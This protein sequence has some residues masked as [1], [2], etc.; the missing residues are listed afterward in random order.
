MNFWHQAPFGRLLLP[1]IGGILCS[2]F[3]AFPAQAVFAVTFALLFVYLMLH[4]YLQKEVSKKLELLTGVLIMLLFFGIGFL[5][6]NRYHELNN[7]AH[8]SY[9]LSDYKTLQ[10]V[11]AP[12][13]KARSVKIT[14]RVT[15]IHT[16][17][18]WEN[19]AGKMLVYLQRDSLSE[20]L[21]Y[22]DVLLCNV[23]EQ[24]V[25]PPRNPGEFNYKRYLLFNNIFHQCYIPSGGFEILQRNQ[26][27]TIFAFAYRIRASL[28]QLFKT[29]VKE[30]KEAAVS[31]ALV[32][33]YV[34]ELDPDLIQ[35]Y[36]NT[37]TLHVLAVSGMHVGIIFVVL[38]MM[39]GFMD[40][41]RKTA[42]LKAILI[43]AFLWGYS[44]VAGLSPSILRAATMFSFITIGQLLKRSSSIYNT[45]AASAFIM[46]LIK[47]TI[48]ASVGFQL[49]YAA[50]LGIVFI[51]PKIYRLVVFRNYAA[52]MIWKVTAVSVAAQVTTFPM[53]LL[54]FHQ[55]PNYFIFSNLII[56][57]LTTIILYVGLGLIAL[58]FWQQAAVLLGNIVFY[59]IKFTNYL[60][61]QIDRLPFATI[62]GVSISIAE[63]VLLYALL[64]SLS[65][66]VIV[67]KVWQLR[68]TLG[69]GLVLLLINGYE[70]YNQYN[71]QEL[72]VYHVPGHS[73]IGT[74]AG[75]NGTLITDSFLQKDGAALRFYIIHHWW[76]NG[77]DR[78]KMQES[79]AKGNSAVQLVAGKRILWIN[80]K[81]PWEYWPPADVDYVILSNNPFVDLARLKQRFNPEQLIFDSSNK[82]RKIKFL[83]QHAA[84]YQ[85]TVY[86]VA[87]QGAFQLKN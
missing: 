15:A 74:F 73:A 76:E 75:F 82:A 59:G 13:I 67:K 78:L 7:S 23:K 51:Q 49:S 63:T 66:F 10:L 41:T 86:D 44:L 31:T 19:S 84:N 72:I 25:S 68:L 21:K 12:V 77:I 1:F 79:V 60:V 45:L 87:E 70:K 32:F 14:A 2:V 47:P 8:F 6:H 58:S 37:G 17:G 54:Y 4:L 27:N 42:V 52:D 34:D 64:A 55:F 24:E 40:K 61:E 46:I 33:C 22:G 81:Q 36:S 3:G 11:E 83:K 62:N 30:S 35:S 26:G 38:N 50:V 20:Q 48:M 43:G 28:I 18:K 85:M 53:G 39:L 65:A 71:Q 69:L 57:P 5:L 56:I 29:Y 9:R 16:R 80:G